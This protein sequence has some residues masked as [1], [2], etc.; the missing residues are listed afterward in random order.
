MY[1]ITNQ[2]DEIIAADHK[3]LI[4]LGLPNIRN[5]YRK[6]ILEEI[7]FK[8][9][10]PTTLVLQQG[11]QSTEYTIEQSTLPGV[12]GELNIIRIME[13]P[14]LHIE[15]QHETVF[16]E[17]HDEA[18]NSIAIENEEEESDQDVDL[19]LSDDDEAFSLEKH[20]QALSLL[21]EQE[22]ESDDD[23]LN[24]SLEEII[25]ES[26]EPSLVLDN[27]PSD[28]EVEENQV[29]L[30]DLQPEEA[31]HPKKQKTPPSALKLSLLK[32]IEE[33]RAKAQKEV[34]TTPI[35]I[36]V[37]SVSQQIG[38]TPKD[39]MRFLDEYIDMAVD[40]E[41]ELRSQDADRR[42]AAI[43]TLDQLSD[44][45]HIEEVHEVIEKINLT[46][47]ADQQ[48]HIATL[49][50]TLSRI[51][52][53]YEEEP[54]EEPKSFVTPKAPHS[55]SKQPS[56]EP[57]IAPKEEAAP[58]THHQTEPSTPTI[59]MPTVDNDDLFTLDLEEPQE[60]KSWEKETPHAPQEKE[61]LFDLGDDLFDLGD[62]SIED[63]S[64]DKDIA[65]HDDPKP[66][67]TEPMGI[68]TP[69]VTPPTMTESSSTS[70]TE[71]FGTIDLSDV[72][73]IR[74]DFRLEE[75]AEDLSLPVEL[76]KEFVN[77]F[78]AQAKVETPKM[79]EA[80]ERGDLPTIQKIGHLLKGAASNLRIGP[81]ADT[82]YEIQFCNDS[83]QLESLIRNYW[84][85]FLSFEKQMKL[86]SH[87]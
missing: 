81:L 24:L 84:A 15:K 35:V 9:T 78:V 54:K 79:L 57:T 58:T 53:H 86:I 19:F 87:Q 85:H 3:L 34:E 68:K 61:E 25:K 43:D 62:L 55:V 70:A 56:P 33:A 7:V 45:L 1:Y 2:S 50:A 13:E 18:S 41:D 10:S 27:S 82:L 14:S 67:T 17:P 6:V 65:I 22:T 28:I 52:T 72:Q 32:E 4:L 46:K 64:K 12:L 44:V 48:A 71:S 77:D 76:I 73:P 75:S 83:S 49:Y 60:E 16:N 47:D 8:L 23:A 39:Y 37:K 26:T 80:Y 30:D 69:S 29:K 63:Q 20:N 51:T 42:N 5:L 40:L 31:S 74:F 66:E 38:I 36:D 21:D 59:E 11:D